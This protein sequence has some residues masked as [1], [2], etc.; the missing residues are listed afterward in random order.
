MKGEKKFAEQIKED[1]P[2]MQKKILE[3]EKKLDKSNNQQKR[4]IE[5]LAKAIS[6]LLEFKDPYSKDHQP[7]VAKLA[8]AIAKMMKLP[9]N[10][11]DGLKIAAL[12]HDIGKINIPTEIIIKPGQL[13]EV[14][15]NLVKNY[16]K[17]AY[18]ILKKIKFPWPIAEI[19]YQ[20]QER[21]NGSGYPRGLKG[22]EI[23]IEAKILAVANVIE[24][25]TSVKSYRPALSI[26][27]AIEEVSRNKNTF[28][29]VE[30]VDVCVSLFNKKRLNYKV[31]GK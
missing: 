24:A 22:K 28:F 18:D 16:P 13:L 21:V 26:E 19:V 17:M 15:F 8:V 4:L 12:I 14:E 25:M 30:V 6:K 10:K 11:I 29:D 27:K 20:H 23:C 9:Q 2:K 3:L 7:R 5:G 1:L 31:K